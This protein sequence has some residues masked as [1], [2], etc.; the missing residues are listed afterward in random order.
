MIV[1]YQY[2]LNL[3]AYYTH[4]LYV[5]DATNDFSWGQSMFNGH[6]RGLE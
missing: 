1:S 3:I 5:I 6:E 2:N 4:L